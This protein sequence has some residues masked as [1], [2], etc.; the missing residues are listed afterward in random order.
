[1]DPIADLSAQ[2]TRLGS[3]AT[4]L[5]AASEMLLAMFPG[6]SV[7]RI[8]VDM[9]R[10]EADA[11]ARYPESHPSGAAEGW[12]ELWDDHPVLLSCING[13]TPGMWQPRRLSDLVSDRELHATR[14]Y[15]LGLRVLGSNRQ[16]S[17]LTIRNGRGNV[18]GWSLN[19]STNDFTDAEVG[20]SAHVQPILRLL[21]IAYAGGE[22]GT[23]G[24]E[25]AEAFLLT[26]R[27][28]EIMELVGR[29][30][31]AIS[32]GHLLGISPRTI[33]KHLEHVYAKLGCNNRIDA[34]RRLN[35]R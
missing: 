7:A 33:G 20:L 24:Q 32:I 21:D 26:S 19:R 1:M 13:Y 12:H 34:L 27:E 14:A 18:E 6:D 16:L 17:F 28:R 4:Y 3:H 25:A 29:G 30:L 8:V 31:T 23:A 10:R 22:R 2:L 5:D 11:H 15:Q 35:S 9:D